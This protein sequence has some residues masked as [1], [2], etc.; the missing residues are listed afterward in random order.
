[1]AVFGLGDAFG[2]SML[3]LTMLLK[4]PVAYFSFWVCSDGFFCFG[5]VLGFFLG[6][7]GGGYF[8]V[9]MLGFVVC[10]VFWVFFL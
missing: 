5:F 10:F 6:I 3:S 1:M 7:W 4:T 9:E 8:P 2:L